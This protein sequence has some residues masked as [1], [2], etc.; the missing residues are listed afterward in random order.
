MQEAQVLAEDHESARGNRRLRLL[1]MLSGMA[2]VLVPGSES[3]HA[4]LRTTL[5]IGGVQ[6]C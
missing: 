6:C 5:G 1:V 3:I 4:G 2:F